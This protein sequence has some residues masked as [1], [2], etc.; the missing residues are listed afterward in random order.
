VDAAD[1]V[2]WR[3]GL[4]TTFTHADYNAW[5][6]HFGRSAASG[7]SQAS[8][9]E[10]PSA[11]LYVLALA[12]LRYARRHPDLPSKHRH[13]QVQTDFVNV[14]FLAMSHW[15]LGNNKEAKQWYAKAANSINNPQRNRTSVYDIFAAPKS[16]ILH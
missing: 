13:L 12:A 8:V 1:Y 15:Q 3:N 10:P 5:R 9:P 2:V 11:V 6:D 16:G 7:A 4:G 14:L